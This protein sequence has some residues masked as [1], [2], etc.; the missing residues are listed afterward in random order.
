MKKKTLLYQSLVICTKEYI[1][2]VRVRNG[3]GSTKVYMYTRTYTVW[4]HF[5]K[6]ILSLSLSLLFV[7][8]PSHGYRVSPPLCTPLSCGLLYNNT[9]SHLL[10]CGGNTR[11][12]SLMCLFVAL[13]CQIMSPLHES[14]SVLINIKPLT[15]LATQLTFRML[16]PNI[17]SK[18]HRFILYRLYSDKE[19]LWAKFF[20]FNMK[21]IYSEYMLLKKYKPF[22]F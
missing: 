6:E 20:F 7:L 2:K 13:L 9:V 14:L 22:L 1:G 17:L 15:N 11:C 3:Y 5:Y 12:S 4:P 18:S 16:K 19:S 21:D 8:T 10:L